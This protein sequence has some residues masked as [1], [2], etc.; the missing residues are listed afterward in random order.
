MTSYERPAIIKAVPHGVA[1]KPALVLPSKVTFTSGRFTAL[2]LGTNIHPTFP[3][4]N[5][6]L[7]LVQAYIESRW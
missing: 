2:A 4:Q 5:S 7:V 3:L 6:H 1:P